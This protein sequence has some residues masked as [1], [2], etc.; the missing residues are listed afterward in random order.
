MLTRLLYVE[1][2]VIYVAV[3]VGTFCLAFRTVLLCRYL[4][5]LNFDC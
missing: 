2:I 4:L 5:S 1:E 3:D